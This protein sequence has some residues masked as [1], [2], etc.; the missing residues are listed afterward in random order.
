MP[1]RPCVS[2]LLLLVSAC[3]SPVTLEGRACPCAEGW[4]CCETTR[5]CLPPQATCP[6]A[7]PPEEPEE[8]C[9]DEHWCWENPSPHARYYR[10]VWA[11]SPEDVWAVGAPGVATRW[12]GTRWE[13]HASATQERLVAL[14]GTRPDD[15][16]AV[17]WGGAVVRWNG[18]AWQPVGTGL[19]QR[20]EAVWGSSP[21]DVWVAGEE[22]LMHW[23]G[24]E[25]SR[26]SEV[27][28]LHYVGLW[29][30]AS[31][32]VWLISMGGAL[33]HWNGQAWTQHLY[34]RSDRVWSLSGVG[35][36]PW[37][38]DQQVASGT[39]RVL[40][41][42]EGQW[43]VMHEGTTPLRSL[44]ARGPGDVWAVGAKG[45]V[46]RFDD[47]GGTTSQEAGIPEDLEH[48]WGTPEHGLWAVGTYGQVLRWTGERW[49]SLREGVSATVRGGYAAGATQAWAVG[50][51]GALLRW[52][53]G[54]WSSFPSTGDTVLR[55]VWAAPSGEGWAV[56]DRGMLV[57]LTEAGPD[58]WTDGLTSDGLRAVWGAD[59]RSLW[60]VGEAG[61]ILHQDGTGWRVSPSPTSATLHALW[62]ASASDLWAVGESGTLLHGDGTGWTVVPL[63]P[64]TSHALYAVWGASASDIW[65]VGARGTLRHYD[66]TRWSPV[67]PFTEVDLIALWGAGPEDVYALGRGAEESLLFHY[68]GK[69]WTSEAVP[70][71][72]LFH[73][74]WG[75]PGTLRVGGFGGA[76]LRYRP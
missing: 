28:S 69:T 10:A 74:L 59:V 34:F 22:V 63:E 8:R 37:A 38:L 76:I 35:G 71:G 50:E 42:R 75:T 45:A 18:R 3:V 65:A 43:N 1:L 21:D 41:Y 13:V 20:L 58:F 49:T 55:G 16:W 26:A 29:G 61:R 27:P 2:L 15:V 70:Y 32:D 14:W 23:N 6:Q 72:G 66:G 68:D 56:G 4:T 11:S 19:T 57:H 44:V 62:G 64:P 51:Q 53:E 40:R 33:W 60:A 12:N 9:F 48:V 31:D 54:H 73:T 39:W 67:L 30:T 46:L 25:W 7:L 17:G 5:T 47:S 52:Q 24:A 36:E